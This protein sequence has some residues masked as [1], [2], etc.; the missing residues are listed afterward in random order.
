MDTEYICYCGLYCE[1]CIIKV[2]VEPSAKILHQQMRD[3]GFEYFIN[4][5]PS[6]EAFWGFLKNMSEAG[7]CV[8]CRKGSGD[9]NC[10]IRLCAQ[11]K[12]LTSAPCVTSIPVNTLRP[13]LRFRLA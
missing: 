11:G 10:P 6:G 12:T 5:I 8:S 4:A 9:P 1:N 13:S 7:V 3:A 2:K